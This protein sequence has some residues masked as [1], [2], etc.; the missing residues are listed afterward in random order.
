MVHASRTRIAYGII[1]ALLVP[2]LIYAS[3][4]PLEYV[5]IQWDQ[6]LERWKAIPW[7]QLG[8]SNRADWIANGLVVI[9]ISYCLCGYLSYQRRFQYH[10][11]IGYAL[12]LLGMGGLI[13]GIEFLQVYFPRRTMS[14]NDIVA[15]CVGA[16]LGLFTW[17][18]I[19]EKATEFAKS[20]VFLNTISQRI[21][22]IAF[23]GCV[24]S[25][26]YSLF[27]FDFVV[28][29]DEFLQKI[30]DGRL[31]LIGIIQEGLNLESLKGLLSSWIRMIPFGIYLG[32]SPPR[33]KNWL[34]LILIPFFLELVQIPI[35][36]KYSSVIDWMVGWFGGLVGVF[37]TT[38]K[39]FLN[40]VLNRRLIWVLLLFSW[41]IALYAIYIGV[42]PWIQGRSFLGDPLKIQQR[43]Q[44]F[45]TPPFLRYYFPSEYNAM[46]NFL[47]KA[48]TLAGLGFL[49]SA[50][51]NTFPLQSR[52]NRF[53]WVMG[54]ILCFSFALEIGQVYVEEQVPDST[55]ILIYLFGGIFGFGL[56]RFILEG[57][58]RDIDSELVDNRGRNQAKGPSLMAARCL[59]GGLVILGLCLAMSHPRWPL[60]QTILGL[61]LA[62]FV[63]FK[64]ESYSFLYVFLLVSADAYPLT[65]LLVFQEYDSLLLSATGGLIGS[66]GSALR[67]SVPGK[68]GFSRIGWTLLAIAFFC[69][70]VV[71]LYRLPQGSFGDQLSVYFNKWNA[72]RVSKGLFWGLTFYC[73]TCAVGSKDRSSWRKGFVLG[74]LASG[75]YIGIW[76]L[77]ERAVFPGLFNLNELYRAT[78]PFF[79]MHI[80]DQHIDAFLVI[81]F[82]IACGA[83]INELRE[84]DKPRNYTRITLFLSIAMLLSHGIFATMSRGPIIAVGVQSMFLFFA[85]I[86][87]RNRHKTVQFLGVVVLSL[88]V[89]ALVFLVSYSVISS[90]FNS[91]AEDTY[92]RLNHWSLVVKKGTSG[93]GGA[94]IGH[95]AGCF[96][97][98]MAIEKGYT[99]PP[100]IWERAE[101][102]GVIRIQS[103]WPNYLDRF[104]LGDSRDFSGEAQIFGAVVKDEPIELY[105]VEKSLLHSYRYNSNHFELSSGSAIR[106]G[107][108]RALDHHQPIGKTLNLLRPVYVGLSSPKHGEICLRNSKDSSPLISDRSS[109]PWMFTC[110]DHLVW[111]AKNFLVH[112]YYEMGLIG[113]IGWLILFV[114]SFSKGV[115]QLGASDAFGNM[116]GWIAL[117]IFGFFIVGMFG[118]LVDTPWLSGLILGCIALVEDPLTSTSDV[119]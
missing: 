105:R 110:D 7:L 81:A 22:G 3:I 82:P 102:Q 77:V 37:V 96:P 38:K 109:Y 85:M 72:I 19:G 108:P 21:Q 6:A 113:V 53:K 87:H 84:S 61:L 52:A 104:V 28:S 35:Y 73:L 9:P 91:S 106:I 36:S 45:V 18:A 40:W 86:L 89:L 83:L 62:V 54:F 16:I 15:G 69:G 2:L 100:L 90:R 115:M 60:I 48:L 74:V 27:P 97:S 98:M 93:I 114:F 43:W 78:G 107:W 118:T 80:G 64:T 32:V 66:S 25:I 31:G 46:T 39:D 79:S 55:D 5:P 23:V 75:L 70:L 4:L 65:G 33:R 117:S 101:K 17:F 47:G 50:L 44:N 68:Q 20:F 99:V 59:G 26:L 71:G 11:L 12:L 49:V 13:V 103:G 116:L 24:A 119:V 67:F 30:A 95:G 94:T 41:S 76:I 1:G 10:L 111:R 92:E 88:P 42:F 58:N 29:R 34:Y 8:V 112:A 51:E 63:Y 57:C 14:I 56:F